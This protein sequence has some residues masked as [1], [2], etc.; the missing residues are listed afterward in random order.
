M[1]GKPP[2]IL[3]S[4][5]NK[6]Q[7]QS[8]IKYKSQ[9]HDIYSRIP[10]DILKETP[11]IE[12][13][14]HPVPKIYY[15]EISKYKKPKMTEIDIHME[16]ALQKKLSNLNEFREMF[17]NY[18]QEEREQLSDFFD[19]QKE[20]NQFS[21]NYK[22][23]Q[24]DKNK[25]STGTYLDHQYLIGIASRYSEKG[26]RVPKI[27]VD[28][29]VFSANPLILGGSDLEHYFLYNLGER[30]KSSVF[31]NK[32]D[33]IV[34][35][36]ITGSYILSEDE[37]RKLELLKKNEKPK[38]YIPPKILIPKLINEI[39]QAKSTYENLDDFDKF[40]ENIEKKDNSQINSR[41]ISKTRNSRSC[42]NIFNNLFK[43]NNK[44]RI[45][46]N[47]SSLNNSN[48][49]FSSLTTKAYGISNRISSSN[50]RNIPSF[51]DLCKSNASSA[52]SREKSNFLKYSPIMSPINR[53]NNNNMY[54]NL[55]NGI[56]KKNNSND[57]FILSKPFDYPE[58][59]AYNILYE[60]ID[61]KNNKSQRN[62]FKN[63][64]NLIIKK[65]LI[66]FRKNSAISKI[67]K[68]TK[69]IKNEEKNISKVQES[70]DE[71]IR[72]LNKELE[73]KNETKI[74][75]E[76]NT[77]NSN[78][79]PQNILTDKINENKLN[80]EAINN[81]NNLEN[82]PNS[83]KQIKKIEIINED[84]ERYNKIESIFNS[85]LGN[86]YKSRR[87]KSVINE[88]LKS[89]G[90]NTTKK[91]TC[92]DA[93]LNINRMKA[94]AIERNFL[95]EEFKIRNGEYSKTPLSHKQQAII[96]KNKFYSK[97]IERNEY[98]LKKLLCEK[99]IEK[100]EDIDYNVDL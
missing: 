100:E 85:I 15:N 22:K 41:V 89:R 7:T 79:D 94:K 18:N 37:K 24:K 25:F 1:K 20:N 9:F 35:R 43:K 52:I 73:G 66:T 96:D 86:E 98:I 70:D 84:D 74:T 72:L 92:K 51:K 69:N 50:S 68:N 44:I 54:N 63:N 5:I 55:Y 12:K 87:S 16:D 53:E 19:V 48:N 26:I 4:K 76:L 32:V 78:T 34:R 39:N 30:K 13:L 10:D 60:N 27:S 21:H 46:K 29:N 82:S 47:I 36:K 45:R 56:T 81:N 42:N 58:K 65:N 95:L 57:F 31:L 93:Y 17:Y 28:K 49:K 2:F 71:E 6:P 62:I 14:I 33:K 3:Y 91:Y 38:G 97:E 80:N 67:L 59:N 23:V 40:F 83:I 75:N 99:N 77:G 8:S 88:F 61:K 11:E 90:Y 64:N